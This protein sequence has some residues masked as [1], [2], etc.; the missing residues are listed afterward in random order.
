M[1][2]KK[3]DDIEEKLDWFGDNHLKG[4]L[5]NLDD[6]NGSYVSK[7]NIK[8]HFDLTAPFK[9]FIKRGNKK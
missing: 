8:E 1:E 2:N 4:E 7:K 6:I 3:D 9:D 5:P